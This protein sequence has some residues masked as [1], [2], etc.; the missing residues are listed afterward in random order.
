[1]FIENGQYDTDS[2]AFAILLFTDYK[3]IAVKVQTGILRANVASQE[4]CR[5][6]SFMKN[7][8]SPIRNLIETLSRSLHSPSTSVGDWRIVV[9]LRFQSIARVMVPVVMLSVSVFASFANAQIAPDMPNPIA[10][11]N[12]L[13][14]TISIFRSNMQDKITKAAEVMPESKYSYR[15]T[16]D[17]RSFA[18]IVTHVADISYY[19]CS[20]AKGEAAPAMATAKGSKTEITAYLKGAFAY[21]D[22]AYAGFTDAHLNDPADFWG[23]KTNKL[24][25]LTQLAN[26]DALHY[27]NLVTYV[28]LNGLEPSGGWF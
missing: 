6:Q 2:K 24:F 7:L 28:R 21:C 19:L 18:E 13:T 23:H 14:T 12:P 17:V 10:A 25:I 15:P 20:N 26:H 11:P 9:R 22:G 1:V 16:K 4:D 5:M 3:E 27:G 8:F